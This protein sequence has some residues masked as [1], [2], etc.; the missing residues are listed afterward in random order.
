MLKEAFTQSPKH[1]ES[2]GPEPLS[3][4]MRSLHN[5]YPIYLTQFYHA[6]AS[7]ISQRSGS[8]SMARDVMLATTVVNTSQTLE[9]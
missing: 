3:F 2:A 8:L 5:L 1:A 9:R 6:Y 7:F 4:L